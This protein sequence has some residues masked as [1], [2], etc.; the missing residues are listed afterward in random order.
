M[1]GTQVPI[2]PGLSKGQSGERA[3][4]RITL[5]SEGNLLKPAA[6]V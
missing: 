3:V 4:L 5:G 1:E 2:D 6:E